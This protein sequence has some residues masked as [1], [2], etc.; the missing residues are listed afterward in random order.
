MGV[1]QPIS[2]SNSVRMNLLIKLDSIR[3]DPVTIPTVMIAWSCDNMFV[4]KPIKSVPK[5]ST[6]RSCYSYN[7]PFMSLDSPHHSQK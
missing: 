1:Y 5:V 4:I 2:Y 3:F 6:K 7:V